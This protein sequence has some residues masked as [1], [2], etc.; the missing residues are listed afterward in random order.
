[1]GKEQSYHHSRK[2]RSGHSREQKRRTRAV[3]VLTVN[4]K[5]SPTLASRRIRPLD[6]AGHACRLGQ[7]D[8]RMYHRCQKS[9]KYRLH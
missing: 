4:R 5:Q 3:V 7:Q 9:R 1:M 8:A 6:H 2:T